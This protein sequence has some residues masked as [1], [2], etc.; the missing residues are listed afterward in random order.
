MW[1]D[2]DKDGEQTPGEPP[3]PGVTVTLY[4]S[5]SVVAV[6][7]TNAA[8]QY[9]FTGLTPGVPYQVAF[10]P[11]DGMTWTRT[12]TTL[13][14]ATDSN[15]ITT[16]ESVAR[17][18]A[19]FSVTDGI[20][21]PIGM[22]A[23]IM[24]A[25]DEFNVTVD[26]GM[27]VAVQLE[28][29]GLGSAPNGRIGAD[30]LITYTLIVTN[31]S[32]RV[33]NNIV[34]SD[35]LPNLLAL[36]PGSASPAPATESPLTWRI[37]VPANGSTT[38]RFTARSNAPVLAPVR[39]VAWLITANTI[40]SQDTSDVFVPQRPTSIALDAFTA[41]PSSSGAIVFWRTAL[42]Q[43]T[44]GFHVFRAASNARNLAEQV[45]T[46]LIAARGTNGGDYAFVDGST[47]AGVAYHYWLQEVEL[48]GVTR[49]YGP[50]VLVEPPLGAVINTA[51]GLLVPVSPNPLGGPA[52]FAADHSPQYVMPGSA[53]PVPQNVPA[54]ASAPTSVQ[55]AATSSLSVA[56]DLAIAAPNREDA[57]A[58]APLPA[59]ARPATVATRPAPQAETVSDAIRAR[60]D[61]VVST[62][63][64]PPAERV[65]LL[66]WWVLPAGIALVVL[67]ACGALLL[68]ILM[69]NARR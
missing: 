56:S 3:L 42:E 19:L 4:L 26:A 30:R 16:G 6:V 39:N 20:T 15:A 10:T 17:G 18:A 45:S 21:D 7:Q 23:P 33:A 36:V 12:G 31:T 9:A 2:V 5:G 8:G 29:S 55:T 65:R 37:S 41:T 67:G 52:T 53:N 13:T 14:S 48:S 27:I 22:S 51:D 32:D 63:A 11:P 64:E 47:I 35:A 58:P 34:I 49:E 50:I 59:E 60:I 28:K 24:L 69:L 68:G 40:V 44:Q 66:P 25:P 54:Q 62:A 38:V 46:R 43:N 1:F 57:V 61:A